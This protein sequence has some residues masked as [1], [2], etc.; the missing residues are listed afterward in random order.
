MHGF[1]MLFSIM[2]VGCSANVDTWESFLEEYA[3]A[4]CMVYKECYRAHY[5]GEYK[6]YATCTEDVI[7]A[8]LQETNE[9]YLDCTF[10]PEKAAD[11]LEETTKSTCGTHWTDQ[12]RIF[13]ACHED[14][15]ICSTE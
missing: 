15:W 1:L 2:W 8:Y 10:S 13:Q 14:I 5:E 4:K 12:A 7:E 6:N 11:C 9:E 3:H